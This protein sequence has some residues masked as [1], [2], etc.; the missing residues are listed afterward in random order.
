[1][2]FDP[3]IELS[4]VAKQRKKILKKIVKKN[5]GHRNNYGRPGSK[6]IDRQEFRRNPSFTKRNNLNLT[7]F[8]VEDKEEFYV[9]LK[10]YNKHHSLITKKMRLVNQ[11]NVTTTSK[12]LVMTLTAL[13]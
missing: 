3:R 13:Q 5:R 12:S 11:I 9:L 4:Y 6:P 10:E 1:M 2:G 7:Q 8:Y